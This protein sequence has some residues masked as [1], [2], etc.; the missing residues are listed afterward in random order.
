MIWQSLEKRI[1][2]QYY[3]KQAHHSYWNGCSTGGRQGLMAAQAYPEDFDGIVAG[4]P[5]IDWARYVVAEQWPQVVMKEEDTFIN[6][7]ILKTFTDAS[8]AACDSLDDVE[9]GVITD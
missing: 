5:A 7:C 9:D 3:G 1:I 4:A 8:I 6:Q 2:H